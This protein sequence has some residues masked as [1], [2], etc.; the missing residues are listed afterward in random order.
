MGQHRHKLPW[1][2]NDFGMTNTGLVIQ[3]F[4]SRS[5]RDA[6]STYSVHEAFHPINLLE[7]ALENF[8]L[9]EIHISAG[10]SKYGGVFVI[11]HVAH[12]V[13]DFWLLRLRVG[14]YW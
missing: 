8:V 4:R 3:T 6:S 2:Q 14:E 11:G 13:V 9:C 1:S 5:N 7:S 12:Q 10:I